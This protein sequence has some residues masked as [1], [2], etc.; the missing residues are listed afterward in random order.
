MRRRRKHAETLGCGKLCD[1]FCG[2]PGQVSSSG[3][4]QG[5][6]DMEPT[7]HIY[8]ELLTGIES[9]ASL[10][11]LS[12]TSQKGT[13]SSSSYI[14]QK[15]SQGKQMCQKLKEQTDQLKT[16]VQEFSKRIKQESPYHLQDKKLVLEK[17]QGHLELLEQNFL[18]TKDKHLTLQQQVHKHESTIVSDFDPERKVEGEIFKLEMLLED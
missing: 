1:V 14:F 16:K 4:R 18:A 13:S 5:I 8:Q 2:R 9:E 10:S 11:K 17:L 6:P 15:I 7:V 12:P 3:G